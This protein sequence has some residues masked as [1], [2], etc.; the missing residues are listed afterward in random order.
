MGG[1]QKFPT[2]IDLP[3]IDF[4]NVYSSQGS[5]RASEAE[6]LINAFTKFGFCLISN[7]PDYDL[8]QVYKAIKYYVIF[9]QRLLFHTFFHWRWFYYQ[10]TSEERFDQLAH[11]SFNKKNENLYRGLFPLIPG[12][13]SHKEGYDMGP[14]N[15]GPESLEEKEERMKN[16]FYGD[17]PKLKF[18]GDAQR[19]AQADDFYQVM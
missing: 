15:F 8:E 16:P 4:A 9:N 5:K 11:K 2:A 19:Q 14:F 17:T 7:L 10:T 1:G 12:K 3:V 6:N 18:D 13:L